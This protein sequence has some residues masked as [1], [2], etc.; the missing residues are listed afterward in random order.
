MI[1][2]SLLTLGVSKT[3]LNRSSS[4]KTVLLFGQNDSISLNYLQI[5]VFFDRYCFQPKDFDPNPT[6]TFNIF[7]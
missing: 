4:V 7:I 2:S 6:F 3:E 5:E 1:Y